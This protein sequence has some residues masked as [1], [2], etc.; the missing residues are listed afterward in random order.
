VSHSLEPEVQIE[1][2]QHQR[3]DSNS[4]FL[5]EHCVQLNDLPVPG[6]LNLGCEDYIMLVQKALYS[7]TE[8]Y[9]QR[10]TYF[11]TGFY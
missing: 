5:Q 4:V 2:A 1:D 7:T 8:L 9:Y 3:R 6:F 11:E 10:F